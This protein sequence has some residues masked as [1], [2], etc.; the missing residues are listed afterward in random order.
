MVG[1]RDPDTAREEGL[2]GVPQFQV[3]GTR[4]NTILD[5]VAA[6][7][8][9]PLPLGPAYSLDCPNDVSRN[10]GSVPHTKVLP[11]LRYRMQSM[12]VIVACDQPLSLGLVIVEL[13]D[14]IRRPSSCVLMT[15]LWR[16]SMLH[17]I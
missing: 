1:L 2:L 15:L 9:S 13:D 10:V 14:G 12:T 3:L 8:T 4:L 6:P 17:G 16:G 7:G 11:V 5:S